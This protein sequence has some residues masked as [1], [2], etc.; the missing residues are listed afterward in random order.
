MEGSRG[1]SRGG[2]NQG[3]GV[4]FG[5]AGERSLSWR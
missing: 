5:A 1:S 3:N 2:V 4:V